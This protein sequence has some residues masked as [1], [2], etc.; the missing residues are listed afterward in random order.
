MTERDRGERERVGGTERDLWDCG[1]PRKM[2]RPNVGQITF[3]SGSTKTPREGRNRSE[4]GMGTVW[5]YIFS[6]WYK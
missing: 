6:V 5:F 1:D 3:F 2:D 4:M